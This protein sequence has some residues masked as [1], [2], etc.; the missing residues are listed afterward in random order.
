MISIRQ[1]P[2]DIEARAVP[3]LISE[4]RNSHIA[5][6]VERHP[7]FVVLVHVNGKDSDSVV[8]ALIRQVQYLPE[9]MMS[10]LTWDRG[11]ELAMHK[12]FTLATDTDVFFRDPQVH[13]SEAAIKIR[14]ACCAN[15]CR[16]APTCQATLRTISTG[17]R[18]ISI[19]DHEKLLAFAPLE[20]HLSM[21]LHWTG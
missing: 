18:S 13:G 15:I 1:R 5:M 7:R 9:G 14:T 21:P 2:A 4:S 6:L 20:L 8:S 16:T 17:S 10:S 11:T 12:R 19:H 3:D